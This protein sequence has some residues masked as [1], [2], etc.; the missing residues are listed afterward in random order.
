MTD[1]KS[2]C[3]LSKIPDL[4]NL[5]RKKTS[6]MFG[7]GHNRESRLLQSPL[8]PGDPIITDFGSCVRRSR[9]LTVHSATWEWISSDIGDQANRKSLIPGDTGLE[10]TAAA[11]TGSENAQMKGDMSAVRWKCAATRG[12]SKKE[13]KKG[14][15]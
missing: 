14:E 13:K 9:S 1:K 7:L 8:S 10:A 11:S 4:E 15:K 3:N 2:L 12:T 5:K 6:F